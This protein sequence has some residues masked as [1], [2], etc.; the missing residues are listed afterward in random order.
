MS[1]IFNVVSFSGFDSWAKYLISDL[2]SNTGLLSKGFKLVTEKGDSWFLGI[3][4]KPPA[5]KSL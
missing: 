5:Q 3:S 1:A 4:A 2:G